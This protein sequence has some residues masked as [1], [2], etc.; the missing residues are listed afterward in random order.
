M[1]I[2]V[3]NNVSENICTGCGACKNI[4]PTDAIEMEPNS[5]GF[6][7]PIVY[8]DKCINC[9]KCIKVCPALNIEYNNT[10]KPK[11]YAVR[12]NDELR[13]VSSSGGMF[14]L[15]ANEILGQGGLVCG[16]AF[17]NEMQ[18]KHTMISSIENLAGL[19]G[20]KYLQSNTEYIYREIKDKLLQNRKV[21]FVGCPCQVAALNCYLKH[22]HTKN[23]ENIITVDL[24]CHG[25]PSQ[26]L[27]S[28]YLREIKDKYHKYDEVLHV[29]FRNK[30]F[31]WTAEH[32]II[33]FKSGKQYESNRK[34]D[35]YLTL[36]LKNLGLRKSCS[37]CPFSVFPRQGDLSIGDFWGISKIDESQNDGKGTSMVFINNSKGKAIFNRIKHDF[38]DHKQIKINQYEIKNR[39]KSVFPANKHRDRF[40][41]FTQRYSLEQSISMSLNSIYDIGLV[42]N[43]LA[44]NFGGSLTQYSLYH[45]LEDMGY[46]VLM[47]ERPLDAPSKL[48]K[49][50]LE[51]IY[52]EKPYPDYSLATHYPNKDA[53][54]E[55]N[56]KCHTFVVGSDQ[57]FQYSLYNA[58]GRFV[59][60]DWVSDIKRKIAYAASFGHAHIWGDKSIL[61]EMAY[62]LKRFDAFSVREESG[63]DILKNQFEIDGEVVLDPVFICNPIH[64]MKLI[65]K[66][67]RKLKDHYIASYILDPTYDKQLI[68]RKA[69]EKLS[70][71]IEIFSE[72]AHSNE[73]VK[74]LGDLNVVQLKIEE[75]LQSIANCDFFITDSFHGT[76]F[77]IIMNKP[78]ISILNRNRGGSRFESLLSMLGLR[79]RL[80]ENADDLNG[81]DYLYSPINYDIVNKTL[82]IEKEKSI[83]WL[84]KA[85]NT[86]EKKSFTDYDILQNKIAQQ[87]ERIEKLENLINKI[88]RSEENIIFIEDIYEYLELLNKYKSKY[89]IFISVK[90]TP[91][92]KLD[93]SIALKL[94][95]LG[96]KTDLQNKHWHSY[97]GIVDSGNLVYEKLSSYN[98]GLVFEKKLKRMHVHVV[99]K[100]F[101]KGNVAKIILDGI[102]YAINKRGLNIVVYD[103]YATKVIDSV[104]FDTHSKDLICIRQTL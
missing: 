85:L 9:G 39:I 49:D 11:I 14:S 82:E 8:S 42:S 26:E 6:I 86:P 31:G 7:V 97:I 99:S 33:K 103:K 22:T 75:R 30:K 90:D 84:N 21:L 57:L 64:F 87:N 1:A 36:F 12:G 67:T 2:T 52:L 48:K 70:L 54:R 53:M 72:L 51:K 60:L 16:A 71:P 43:Y 81:K 100:P 25:V 69:M 3:V 96:L 20:S 18:L 5:E 74:P 37:D 38:F 23:R 76:C 62:Y 59:S 47:I 77:A 91:G 93:N 45:T 13:A 15:L 29:D 66:S 79:D 56:D 92:F 34:N 80:I 4:C 50:M 68:L 46:S 63:I 83:K 10:E 19:R 73:Y 104:C 101:K 89:I 61:S 55:L 24:L 41:K 98:E 95:S 27:F 44:D 88:I 40:L 17:D 28:K 35:P 32:I 78:F 102:D 65:D 94:M 58:L